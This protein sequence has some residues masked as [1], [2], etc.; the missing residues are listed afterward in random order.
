MNPEDG[1]KHII[2]NYAVGV[3]CDSTS[4]INWLKA[5]GFSGS[6]TKGT[7]NTIIKKAQSVIAKND[8]SKS[9]L[10]WKNYGAKPHHQEMLNM[11]DLFSKET[12]TTSVYM[13]SRKFSI[14]R[15]LERLYAARMDDG[16]KR[17]GFDD[18]NKIIV[19][20]HHPDP[21]SAKEWKRNIQP[22]WIN[23]IEYIF[24]DD[25][26]VGFYEMPPTQSDLSASMTIT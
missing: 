9:G 25:F 12:G 6:S 11:V 5:F 1:V 16:K 26:E 17:L 15:I 8:L 7:I 13:S 21:E 22:T 23:I 2:D 20:I 14:E 4:N 3:P 19:V 10:L 24:K 18:I